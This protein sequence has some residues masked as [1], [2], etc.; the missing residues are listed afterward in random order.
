MSRKGDGDTAYAPAICGLPTHFGRTPGD[1]LE[2]EKC[3]DRAHSWIVGSGV[4]TRPSSSHTPASRRTLF[5]F[6]THRSSAFE[7]RSFARAMRLR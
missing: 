4:I 7:G 2:G 3:K 1:S 5:E 6:S